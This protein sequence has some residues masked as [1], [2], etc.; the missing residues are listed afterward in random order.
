MT[1]PRASNSNPRT[2]ASPVWTLKAILVGS[3][4]STFCWVVSKNAA[5]SIKFDPSGLNLTPISAPS[6]VVGSN[7][8]PNWSVPDVGTND[9]E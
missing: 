3:A 4:V 1:L 8:F 7:M 6:P 5:V 2:R 9:V